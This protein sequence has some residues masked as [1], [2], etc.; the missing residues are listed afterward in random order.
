MI[1]GLCVLGIVFISTC[2]IICF[3]IGARTFQN[4][5]KGEEIKLP[6]INPIEK[7]KDVREQREANKEQERIKT[8]WDNVNNYQGDSTGQKDI[9]S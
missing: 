2:N 9:P 3:L 1:F 8:I 6:N 4:V 5:H 7:I